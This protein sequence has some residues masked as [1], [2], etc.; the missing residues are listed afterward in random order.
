MGACRFS[1]SVFLSRWVALACAIGLASPAA[2]P[3][4]GAEAVLVGAVNSLTG[5]FA[6]Q[7]NAVQ[8]GLGLAIQEAIVAG[9]GAGVTIELAT[10]DDEGK[11]DRAVAAA[12]YGGVRRSAA[13]AMPPRRPAGPVPGRVLALARPAC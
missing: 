10:R 11:P 9:R 5:R 8:R 12:G 2:G 1:R 7:G 3:A 6:A 13:P 4:L